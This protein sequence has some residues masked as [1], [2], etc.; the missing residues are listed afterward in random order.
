MTLTQIE[1]LTAG[2]ETNAEIEAQ[3]FGHTTIGKAGRHWYV[4]EHPDDPEHTPRPPRRFSTDVMTALKILEACPGW[5]MWQTEESQ[6]RTVN[7]QLT[8]RRP[9]PDGRVDLITGIG[10][11]ISIALAI[12]KAG[13]MLIYLAKGE[14]ETTTERIT[15]EVR[16]EDPWRWNHQEPKSRI[17]SEEK[18]FDGK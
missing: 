4:D 2:P 15:R 1:H 9:H 16:Q 14:N 17:E 3:F 12:C 5:R 10:R 11:D 18:V 7:V 6:I 8:F 13:L